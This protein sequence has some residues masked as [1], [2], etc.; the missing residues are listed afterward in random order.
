MAHFN[1]L[2][3]N[4]AGKTVRGKEFAMSEHELILRLARRSLTIISVKCSDE[5]KSVFRISRRKKSISVFDQMVFCRQLATLLK[6][7]VPLI[8]GL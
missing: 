2:A 5:T 4:E 6:G 3:K 1:Y 8:K 7:G